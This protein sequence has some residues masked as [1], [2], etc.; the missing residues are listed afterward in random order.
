[1]FPYYRQFPDAPIF[2]VALRIR[3]VQHAVL[4]APEGPL[5]QGG[6]VG[7]RIGRGLAVI[8]VVVP[9]TVHREEQD[10]ESVRDMRI[11]EIQ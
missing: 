11:A 3:V 2:E 10:R 8:D 1:M 5:V 6:P 4:E 9:V 7:E